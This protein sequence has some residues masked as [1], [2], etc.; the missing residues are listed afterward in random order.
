MSLSRTIYHT[1]RAIDTGFVF[2]VKTVRNKYQVNAELLKPPT[3]ARTYKTIRCVCVSHKTVTADEKKE[4]N[5]TSE[6]PLLAESRVTAVT[7]QQ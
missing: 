3:K 2:Q 1:L 7:L 4:A 5:P 6:K